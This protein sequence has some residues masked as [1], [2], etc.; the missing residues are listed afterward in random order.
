ML[1]VNGSPRS[2]SGAAQPQTALHESVSPGVFP[3]VLRDAEVYDADII[4][5]DQQV[6]RLD[7]TMHDSAVMHGREGIGELAAER[8][9]EAIDI[10]SPTN[11][12]PHLYSRRYAVTR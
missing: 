7:I 9:S 1:G 5:A 3:D 10:G 2:C 8:Q 6:G 12:E 11:P 4:V